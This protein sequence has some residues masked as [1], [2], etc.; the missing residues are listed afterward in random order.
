MASSA[1]TLLAALAAVVAMTALL[2]ATASA[3]SYTVGDSSGWD[4]GIDYGAW[5]DGK[6]FRV[7][8]TLGTWYKQP[9]DTHD[10]RE[11]ELSHD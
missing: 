1:I 9:F 3:A 10:R 4:L 7:G 8:D 11:Y 5:A 2:P 6:K